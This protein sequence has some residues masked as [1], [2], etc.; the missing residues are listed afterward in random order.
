MKIFLECI[1][2]H[3]VSKRST[4]GGSAFP[5]TPEEGMIHF[6]WADGRELISRE[7]DSN[8]A[9]ALERHLFDNYRDRSI[10]TDLSLLEAL[11]KIK[12]SLDSG[13]E[14]KNCIALLSQPLP[15]IPVEQQVPWAF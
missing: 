9:G 8:N 7:G 12:D 2:M 14:L 15:S 4:I 11:Q 3:Q 6:Y 13:C 1:E 10:R 5:E